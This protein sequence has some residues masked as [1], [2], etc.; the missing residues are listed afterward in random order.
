MAYHSKESSSEIDDGTHI[1]KK[2]E[3]NIQTDI[4][5]ETIKI[6]EKAT[7][8]VKTEQ[9]EYDGNIE[10][11]I[12]NAYKQDGFIEISKKVFDSIK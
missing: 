1:Y 12:I 7:G 9:H 11:E 8:K 6:K 2:V 5:I 4:T 10:Q 3:H